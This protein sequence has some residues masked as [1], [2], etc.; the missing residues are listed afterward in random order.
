M[1][2]DLLCSD[3]IECLEPIRE[4]LEN[5]TI[6]SQ[7]LMHNLFAVRGQNYLWVLQEYAQMKIDDAMGSLF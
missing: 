1:V 2:E 3:D 6:P 4:T 5:R 7:D